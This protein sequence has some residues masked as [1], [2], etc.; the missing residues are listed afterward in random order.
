M[1]LAVIDNIAAEFVAKQEQLQKEGRQYIDR[2]RA[3]NHPVD[4]AVVH[5]FSTRRQALASAA[6]VEIQSK[7]SKEGY[8]GLQGYLDMDFKNSI[9]QRR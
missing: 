1:E 9:H 6:A 5:R 2:Y 4:P 8:A 3:A 7:L